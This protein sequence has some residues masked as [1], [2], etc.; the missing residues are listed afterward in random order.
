MV[1]GSTLF[2]FLS[3]LAFGGRH[4]RAEEDGLFH[5]NLGFTAQG[6]MD[7]IVNPGSFAGHAHT[8]FGSSNFRNV[9]NTPAEQLKAGCSATDVTVDMSNY[10]IPTLYFIN[11]EGKYEIVQARGGRAYY[12]IRGDKNV[13]FPDGFRMIA[14]DA[15]NRAVTDVK[16]AGIGYHCRE[17]LK[18]EPGTPTDEKFSTYLPNGTL[19][20]IG[21]EDMVTRVTFPSC[22]WANQSLD[23]WDHSSHMTFPLNGPTGDGL[24]YYDPFAGSSCPS[25]HPIKY[26]TINLEVYWQLT[27]KQ[28]SQWRGGKDAI[29][30][31]WANGDTHGTSLHADFVFG[32]PQD[33]FAKMSKG[34]SD[35]NCAANE[36][37]D[38]KYTQNCRF[39]GMLPDEDLGYLKPLDQLPGCNPRWDLK[40]GEDKPRDCPWFTH[41]PGWTPANAVVKISGQQ[42]PTVLDLPG[43]TNLTRE[44]LLEYTQDKDLYTFQPITDVRH[45]FDDGPWYNR[46]WNGTQADIDANRVLD[47]AVNK[48]PK[49]IDM[50]D[51]SAF[52]DILPSTAPVGQDKWATTQ[53][54]G[55]WTK[56]QYMETPPAGG[57]AAKPVKPTDA[58]SSGAG[59]P[60]N[61]LLVEHSS[62]VTATA[63][64]TTSVD[65]ASSTS[66]AST[67]Q[68]TTAPSVVGTPEAVGGSSSA[69][70]SGAAAGDTGSSSATG[71]VE[72]SGTPAAAGS[73]SSS[74]TG[75]VE[76]SG[77]PATGS[78]SSSGS[79]TAVATDAPSSSGS[80]TAVGTD[81]PS[82]S[83]SG[84]AVVSGTTSS[85]SG[86]AVVSGTA[87]AGSGT[88]TAAGT[89]SVVPTKAVPGRCRPKRQLRRSRH[90]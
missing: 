36:F 31:I 74:A 89:P 81:A 59:L 84:T 62:S 9:L 28:Q 23:S 17:H 82:S 46:W 10:W 27:K 26:P 1:A 65:A 71:S 5:V 87:S 32:W 64:P 21:C 20:D 25:T 67:G 58:S 60:T 6:R 77:T 22:G 68:P 78:P 80:G 47:T 18:K 2:F 88:P 61:N 54:V 3:A 70:G 7:P 29:N 40:D 41:E 63:T 53:E 45:E 76:N 37:K 14:G 39:E 13:P 69:S 66:G 51:D 50:E 90:P 24:M 72:Y 52:N 75:S 44:S 4:A 19:T 8:I 56:W 38:G 86:T 34:C 11:S 43:V 30:F 49:V 57:V 15:M 16:K 42:K 12:I 85:G 83:G 73:S 33:L 48:Q 35:Q 55:T 79:G